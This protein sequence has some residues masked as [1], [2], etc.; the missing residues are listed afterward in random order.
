MTRPLTPE[1]RL[2]FRTADLRCTSSELRA[3]VPGI[4]DWERVIAIADRE[5]ATPHVARALHDIEKGIPPAVLEDG[6]RRALSLEVRMQYLARR[7]QQTCEALAA[8]H[9]PCML[10]KGA[11][12]G[13]LVDPTFRTRPMNDADVLV[14][15]EDTGRASEALEASGWTSTPDEVLHELL[16][17]AHHLPPFVDP[18]MPSLRLELHVSHLPASHPFAFDVAALW[19]DARRAAP[20]FDGALL[21]SPEHLVLHAAM[22][23]AWQHAMS[24][25]AWRT[26]R[27]ISIVTAMSD[28]SWE[29]FVNMAAASRASTTCFWTLR[30]ANRLSGIDV[31][32]DVLRRLTPPTPAR[33]LAALERHFI[34]AIAVGEMPVSPSVRLDHLLWLAAIRPGWSGHQRSRYWDHEN[35]WGQAY[36]A[37]KPSRWQLFVRHLS[38]YRRWTSFVTR[39]LLGQRRAESRPNA[40]T[41]L[42]GPS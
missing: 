30:L 1:S 11:A 25:G 12:V 40:T 10:L 19:R 41:R 33:V 42:A 36:G 5:M 32:D 16:A 14:R 18:Q 35:K 20:P 38:E 29:R 23:F 15:Q 27:V 21:P 6:R 31:P 28:F 39:T 8:R 4:S 24:F 22:H 37:S 26:F 13:A 7:L 2:V 9:I 17:G 34:A 3:L